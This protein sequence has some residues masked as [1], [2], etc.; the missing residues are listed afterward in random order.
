MA[1]GAGIEVPPSAVVPA[2][3]AEPGSGSVLDPVSQQEVAGMA[4]SFIDAVD[5]QTAGGTSKE[6]AW[7]N[8]QLAADDAFRARYGWEAFVKESARANTPSTPP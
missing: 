1:G 8:Q 7:R 2:A 4:N 5:Q 3:L 6:Q